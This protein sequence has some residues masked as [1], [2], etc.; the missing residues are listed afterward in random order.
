MPWDTHAVRTPHGYPELHPD[1]MRRPNDARG[2]DA[3]REGLS[4][5]HA[6]P[7]PPWQAGRMTGAPQ[8]IPAHEAR[9]S[10][11][12][13]AFTLR[14]RR[15][16]EHSVLQDKERVLAW[17]SVQ[18]HFGARPDG[19]MELVQELPDEEVFESA[20]ARVRPIL[21]QGDPVSHTKLIPALSYFLQD[22]DEDIRKTLASLRA[23]WKRLLPTGGAQRAYK[24]IVAGPGIPEDLQAASD[25]EL[26][27]GWFYGDV[28]HADTDRKAATDVYG[29]RERYR[30][31]VGVVAGGLVMTIRT[32]NFIRQLDRAG[33]ISV[34]ASVWEEQVTVGDPV[35]RHE[36]E[37]AHTAEVGTPLPSH[38]G[39]DLDGG[40]TPWAG[41]AADGGQENAGGQA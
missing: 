24:V 7:L 3:Q 15:I 14:A 30:A 10:A 5:A 23:D 2:P 17:A 9:Y 35:Y 39:E 16:E 40:F 38:A 31:A 27:M 32:L 18:W 37:E 6:R 20:A 4:H 25:S 22:A 36:L 13:A 12:I 11:T 26:A 1:P 34:P 8:G 28:V 19:R 29:I 41:P 33:L 21:L